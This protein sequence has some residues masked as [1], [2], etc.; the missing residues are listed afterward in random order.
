MCEEDT[1]KMKTIF[2]PGQTAQVFTVILDNKS[3]VN[4]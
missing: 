3:E 2:S 4:A 1:E